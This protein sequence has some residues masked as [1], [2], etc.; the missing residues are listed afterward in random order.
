MIEAVDI[1]G[2]IP[3]GLT[4]YPEVVASVVPDIAEAV[5]NKIIQ[6][7]NAE[8]SISSVDY[9]NNVQAIK[10]HFPSGRIPPGE[11]TVASIALHGW[12]PNAIENGWAGGDMTDAILAGRAAKI[13]ET[14]QPYAVVPFRHGAPSGGRHNFQKMGSAHLRAGV[15]T[16]E[17][18]TKMGRNL[19]RKA[20][21]LSPSAP[22]STRLATGDKPGSN[23]LGSGHSPAL[24]PHHTTSIHTG[25]VRQVKYHASGKQ[26]PQYKTFRTVSRKSAGWVHPGIE[27]HYFFAA[28][29]DY[30]GKVAG[31]LLEQAAIGLAKGST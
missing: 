23:R 1:T 3:V 18:A 22:G 9:V 13:D 20:Q 12:L 31:H 29:G 25:M 27:P 30:A 7:A 6:L 28:A 17:S 26:D 8:L 10:Y 5:R 14:G 24:K 4:G 21:K 15:M 16:R 11:H 19:H 2:M